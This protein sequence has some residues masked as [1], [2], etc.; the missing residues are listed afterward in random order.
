MKVHSARA[1]FAIHRHPF[2][3]KQLQSQAPRRLDPIVL[4]MD[5]LVRVSSDRCVFFARNEQSVLEVRGE[6]GG[7]GEGALYERER[8]DMGRS[9]RLVV[10]LNVPSLHPTRYFDQLVAVG[11]N[12][13]SL[14]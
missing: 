5:R 1:L 6:V 2:N 14:G 12:K 13:V 7:D 10:L 11:S 3:P 4:D 9:E 8:F